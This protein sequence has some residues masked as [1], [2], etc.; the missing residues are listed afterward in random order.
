MLSYPQWIAVANLLLKKDSRFANLFAN[1]DKKDSR[2]AI[3]LLSHPQGIALG[4]KPQVSR[5]DFGQNAG[6]GSPE[7]VIAPIA[8]NRPN[9]AER[10]RVPAVSAP[11]KSAPKFP[12]F[13]ARSVLVPDAIRMESG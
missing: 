9:F 13:R 7:R 1:Q 2:F 4:E 3:L 5:S 11:E 6:P 12:R 10:S 8:G